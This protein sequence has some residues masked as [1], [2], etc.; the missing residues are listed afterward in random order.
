MNPYTVWKLISITLAPVVLGMAIFG[1]SS[2]LLENN[3][4]GQASITTTSPVTI[5]ISVK[6]TI[7]ATRK[8]LHLAKDQLI[9]GK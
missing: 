3:A 1:A 6:S 9:K 2:V 7:L 8:G 4:K 5:P